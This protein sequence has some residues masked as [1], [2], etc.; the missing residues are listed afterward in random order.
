MFHELVQLEEDHPELRTPDSPTLRVG[1]APNVQLAE[2][3]HSSPMGSLNNAFSFEEVAA[4]DARVRRLLGFTDE[5]PGDVRYV[6]ELKIDGL[7]I[8]LRY[9]GGR[10]VQGATRGDGT[11]GEDVTANLRTI[12]SIPKKLAEPVDLEVRGEVLHAQGRVRAHQRRARGGRPAAVRQSAQQRRRLAAPDRPA[13]DRQP[14]P[15][16][17]VLRSGRGRDA[18][19]QPVGGARPH[20]GARLSGRAQ[21][22][23]RSRTSKA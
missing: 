15:R 7:A 23:R 9:R 22:R 12:E 19:T 11:T 8:S 1:G 3:R 5:Q 16:R 20:G 13:G 17:V 21:P 4:F 14:A 10:F 18:A 6:T 2:V